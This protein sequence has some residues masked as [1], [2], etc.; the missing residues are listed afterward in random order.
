[1]MDPEV[2]AFGESLCETR[3]K[4]TFIV[5]L[6]RFLIF[7]MD[8]LHTAGVI[9]AFWLLTERLLI[10][11]SEILGQFLK[12][13][14]NSIN[15][16]FRENGLDNPELIPSVQLLRLA[17]TLPGLQLTG[18]QNWKKRKHTTGTFTPM[19]PLEDAA[20]LD[21]RTRLEFRLKQSHLS[22]FIVESENQARQ[23]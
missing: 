3:P 23:Q 16:N 17:A 20:E 2:Q 14:A 8:H 22:Q 6:R 13:R 9:G 18:F 12:I 19:M 1:M 11:H 7:V 15:A 4:L 21:A 10:S 5:N